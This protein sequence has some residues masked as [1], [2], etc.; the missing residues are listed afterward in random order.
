MRSAG[1][2]VRTLLPNNF[3]M[4]VEIAKPLTADVFA[5]GTQG[6]HMRIF[7]GLDVAF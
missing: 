1:A 4:T 6:D 3:R 2:G 5:Q 7:V